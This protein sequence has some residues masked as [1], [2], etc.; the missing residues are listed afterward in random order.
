M[1]SQK[2]AVALT[3]AQIPQEH[4]PRTHEEK[5]KVNCIDLLVGIN[6]SG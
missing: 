5:K 1:T 3:V 2:A 4:Y 6:K